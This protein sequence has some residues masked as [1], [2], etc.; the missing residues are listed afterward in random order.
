VYPTDTSYGLACDPRLPEAL[1]KLFAVKERNRNVG[2]PLLFSDTDQIQSYHDFSNLELVLTRLFWP[3]HLTLVVQAKS[4]VPE[5]LTGG[6]ST[7]AVRVP[8]HVV[9]RGIAKK[10]DSPIVGTSANKSGGSSPFDLSSAME[11]LGNSVDLYIDGG[12]SASENSSTIIGVEDEQDGTSNIKVYR[13]GQ[14]TIQHLI[15]SLRI[16]ADAIRFWTTRVTYAEM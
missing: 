2:V 5:Y 8:D 1:E 14:L 16:D 13:E 12:K 4:S 3:G 6:H 15:D 11:Q 9:P 10:I 7:V